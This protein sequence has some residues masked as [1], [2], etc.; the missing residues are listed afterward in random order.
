VRLAARLTGWRIDIRSESQ[1][2]RTAS[3]KGDNDGGA[4]V[5]SIPSAPS[6]NLAAERRDVREAVAKPV[7]VVVEEGPD[8]DAISYAEDIT[9]TAD[10]LRDFD[11]ED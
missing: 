8:D 11:E 5:D 3:E 9:I 10:M 2:A 6:N 7:A 1:V 4:P